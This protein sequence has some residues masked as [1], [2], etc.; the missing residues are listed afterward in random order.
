MERSSACGF[1]N[2]QGSIWIRKE[3]VPSILGCMRR[4]K[5][6]SSLCCTKGGRANF[7]LTFDEI[8]SLDEMFSFPEKRW[9]KVWIRKLLTRAWDY[10]RSTPTHCILS[11]RDLEN[12]EDNATNSGDPEAFVNIAEKEQL[13]YNKIDL[14]MKKTKLIDAP[15]TST[16]AFSNKIDASAAIYTAQAG[17]RVETRHYFLTRR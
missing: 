7:T 4:P 8:F 5:W 2:S 6:G 11:N 3:S 13:V 12:I 9:G 15:S 17:L 10:I 16:M 1:D 14:W